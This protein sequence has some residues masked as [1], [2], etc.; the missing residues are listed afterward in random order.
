MKRI[1]SIISLAFVFI[2]CFS[3]STGICDTTKNKKTKE[4][5]AY[6]DLCDNPTESNFI[7][8]ADIVFGKH[9]KY[10]SKSVLPDG[11]TGIALLYK[12][13][14]YGTILVITSNKYGN[15]FWEYSDKTAEKA[16]KAFALVAAQYDLAVFKNG[17][18][19]KN[20]QGT[21]DEV[22][23]FMSVMLYSYIT[24]SNKK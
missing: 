10:K 24:D 13:K 5:K 6:E 15:I 17:K 7:T 4:D 3:I 20:I 1:K 16:C 22:T 2:L 8:Y 21:G 19:G 9:Q 12:V 14:K 11:K 23:P 18:S